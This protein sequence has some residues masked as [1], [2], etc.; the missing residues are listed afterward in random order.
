MQGGRAVS[1][2]G[3]QGAAGKGH[4]DGA[5]RPPCRHRGEHHVRAGRP[6][7]PEAAAD[8]F[9][10]DGDL[11]LGKLEQCG[12]RG[13][14]GSG[15]LAGV[16]HDEP[17]VVPVGGGR[18][19]LHGVVVQGRHAVGGVDADR[20]CREGVL[21][22]A[23][24]PVP[25]IPAVGLLGDVR[26]GV[27]VRERHVMVLRVVLDT[28]GAGTGPGRFQRLGDDQGDRPTTVRHTGV[29]QDI[30]RGIVGVGEPGSVLVGE[31]GKDPG[32]SQRVGGVDRAD[33]TAGDR[34]GDGPGV[35][36]SGDGVFGCVAGRARDLLAAFPALGGRA[37]CG[38]RVGHGVLLVVPGRKPC[39]VLVV[40]GAN[41]VRTSRAR[42]RARR[43]L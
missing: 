25:G 26:P 7:G 43:T 23:A 39:Q 15:S 19:R 11:L 4:G 29:L 30:E 6:L 3:R 35:N 13:S 37:Q 38:V 31:H 14:Y 16:V 24:V 17:V 40:G 21:G 2:E 22:L 9:R 20:G 10:H 27:A 42:P 34:G 12:Q 36:A 1:D 32:Q 28:D 18:V 5:S 8:V 41:R 33:R